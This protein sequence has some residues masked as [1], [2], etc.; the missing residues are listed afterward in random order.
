[1]KKALR[2][3][4]VSM[5]VAI[6]FS[7]CGGTS[8]VTV[9]PTYGTVT[10]QTFYDNLSPYGTW[11]DYPNY[12]H[13][14]NPHIDGDFRPYATNGHWASS[15][16]G[17]AWASDYNWGW[18]PFHYGRW[19][20]DDMYG[21]L[22]IPGYDWSPAWV[23]WGSVDNFYCWAPL[24]P[25]ID[26]SLQFGSWR[27]HSIYWNACSRDHIYDRNLSAAIQSHDQVKT[28]VKRITIINNF[29]T[30]KT[31]NLYYSKGPDV[32][33]VQKY[34]KPRI[35]ET[36]IRDVNKASDVKHDGNVMQV[37]RPVVQD[38]KETVQQHPQKPLQ[39]KE[40]RKAEIPQSK[41]ITKEDQTPIIQRTEQKT[42][43]ERLPMQHSGDGPG[44]NN[45]GNGN[46]K[47]GGKGRLKG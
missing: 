13:V 10:Y 42:N 21:W 1:M 37:Y 47:G 14:W 20:Y 17:W 34:V 38:P 31:H 26:A 9:G 11:I 5:V 3:G 36:S 15:H 24:M 30:T 32:Q 16:E 43:I 40:F 6:V 23:T 29:N 45:N 33:E 22:W 12:G 28:V 18:A 27:P 2:S 25:A 41:P 46:G 44:K 39:P 19:L 7:G 35:D 8:S 4:F